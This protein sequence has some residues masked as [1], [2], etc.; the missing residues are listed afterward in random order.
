[1]SASTVSRT[2]PRGGILAARSWSKSRERAAARTQA[3]CPTANSA[4]A[5]PMPWEAPVMRM[6]D[7]IRLRR[8]M[9]VFSAL[10]NDHRLEEKYAGTQFL[11][12]FWDRYA[13]IGWGEDENGAQLR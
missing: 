3:P 4:K 9:S 10:R 5:R 12:H 1:M 13:A 11:P 2:P 7:P 6:R 8:L